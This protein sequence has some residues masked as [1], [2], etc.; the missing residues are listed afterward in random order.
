MKIPD[1]ILKKWNDLRSY[2]DGKEIAEKNADITENNVTRAFKN[3]KCSDTVFVA[4]AGF[5][6]EKEEMVK[7]FIETPQN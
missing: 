1:D 2:G 4:M 6:K 5:Y 3:G 7:P